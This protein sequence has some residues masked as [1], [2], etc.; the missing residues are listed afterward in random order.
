M[1]LSTRGL[2]VLGSAPWQA[3]LSLLSSPT[4]RKQLKQQ[5]LWALLDSTAESLP[6]CSVFPHLR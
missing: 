4:A 5:Q 2:G 3:D 1:T 6:S